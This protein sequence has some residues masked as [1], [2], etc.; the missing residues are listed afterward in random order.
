MCG[1]AGIVGPGVRSM[2]A[3]GRVCAMTDALAHRGPDEC[4]YWIEPSGRAA[5]GHRRLSIIDLSPEGLQP[6]ASAGGRYQLTFNGEVYNFRALRGELERAGHR[7][8]G[9]SDTEVM[10]AAFE[11][12]GVVG[13]VGRFVGM[14]AFAVW[15]GR[16]RELCL[17]R[18][19]LGEKPLYYGRA[20][21]DFVFASELN[22]LA[23]HPEWDNAVSQGAAALFLRHNYIPAPH[24][25]YRDAKKLP[26]G[27]MLRVRPDESGRCSDERIETYWSAREAARAGAARRFAGNEVEAVE[28]LD[29]LLRESVVGQMVADVPLG[30]FLSGGVDSATV[31][32]LMQAASTRPV[33]TFTVGFD[34]AGYDESLHAR[35]VADFLGTEHTELRV[36]AA[37]A[38]RL[39]PRLAEIYD[40]PFADSSQLPTCLV[41]QLARR[42]VTVTLSGDGGDELFGGYGRYRLGRDWLR[43]GRIPACAR[44]SAARLLEGLPPRVL[45]AALGWASPLFSRYRP[46][47]SPAV[48]AA[49]AARVLRLATPGLMYRHALSQWKEPGE[50]MP[51]VAEPPD[52]FA[53]LIAAGDGPAD[54]SEWMMLADTVGYLPDDILV[55]LDRASMAA[56]LE[57]RA[58]LLDHRIV[59]FAWSLPV[60][61]KVRGSVGKWPLRQVLYRRVPRELVERPKMGFAAP[62]GTW[63]R[64][65]LREWAESLLC[66]RGLRECGLEPAP[67]RRLW[68][69]HVSGRLDRHGEL[70]GVLML[71]LWQQHRPSRAPRTETRL[72]APAAFGSTRA[73]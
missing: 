22:A 45:D 46:D 18:D 54:F 19:R 20:G 31:V 70:W 52:A 51:G 62:L 42:H 58:P 73:A 30:A 7:F 37:E 44:Q 35:A 47:G 23:A 41:S 34:E 53:E 10:L 5:F 50:L 68:A 56:G 63:L 65:P 48:L 13:A 1:I 72:A 24:T 69:E 59:E 25:I 12:W 3:R 55:K 43:A 64:G 26:P 28:R 14:F 11:E 27:T 36:G 57:A 21:H 32:S 6:M 16:E 38:C 2:E 49:K 9:S 8:R 61:M 39:L 17:V 67:V 15:D 71:R 33:K 66:E 60:Q 29:E 40:E 4:G